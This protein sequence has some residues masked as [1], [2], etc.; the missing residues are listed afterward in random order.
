MLT[1]Q[2]LVYVIKKTNNMIDKGRVKKYCCEDESLI[3]NYD[4][5]INDKTQTWHIHH[6]LEDLGFSQKDLKYLQLYYG[7]PASELIFMTPAEHCAHH[8]TGRVQSEETK[9]RNRQS[10]AKVWTP[11]KRKEHGLLFK[12]E[13]SVHFGKPAW[14]SGLKGY[15]ES[16]NKLDL[17][18]DTLYDLYWNKNL[19]NKE[20][21]KIL[22]CSEVS[23]GRYMKQYKIRPIDMK[24]VEN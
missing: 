19:S 5:A 24:K 15:Q 14:N 3:E 10:Q 17:D 1:N 6:R 9:E 22:N 16:Y 13:K 12:G 4:K 23:V 8:S 18:K 7:V 20:I 21:A 2:M 11:E